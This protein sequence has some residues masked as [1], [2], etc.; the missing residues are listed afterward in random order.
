MKMRKNSS[1]LLGLNN[2]C[3][4]CLFFP[5]PIVSHKRKELIIE[6]ILDQDR[7]FTCHKAMIAPRDL[8]CRGFFDIHKYDSLVTSLAIELNIVEFVELGDPKQE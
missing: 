4:E 2:R 5:N 1:T 8:C 3:D 7:Y 6:Q